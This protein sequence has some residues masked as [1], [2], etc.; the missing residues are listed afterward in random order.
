M[1]IELE[2]KF[3]DIEPA[4][5]RLVLKKAGAVLVHP[6]I[7]MRRKVYEHTTNKQNDWF[8][9]REEYGKITLS[10]KKLVNRTLHGTQDITYTVPDFEQACRFLEAAQL[11]FI[12]YQETKR[13][14]WK[15]GGVEI[16]I[17][18]WPWI[19]TF[20]EIEAGDE[21]TLKTTAEKLGF[22]WQDAIHGSVEN[23]YIQHF[24]V[25]E[26]EIDDWPDIKFIPVPEWLEA[27]RK[28]KGSRD[29]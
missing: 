8:R 27:K 4:K 11:K 2:A 12:S 16:T 26:K 3:T 24:N 6:E 29:L 23:V 20:V 15:L 21:P 9:V 17:D 19:P 10:Y 25:T 22:K 7:L 28:E 1:D 14:T 18:T 13:E 5:T